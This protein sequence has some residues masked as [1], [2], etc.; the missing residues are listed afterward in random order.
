MDGLTASS[1]CV[2]TNRLLEAGLSK[3]KITLHKAS[4]CL[5]KICVEARRA[6]STAMP[7]RDKRQCDPYLALGQRGVLEHRQVTQGG[8]LL[9]TNNGRPAAQ[10]RG[11]QIRKRMHTASPHAPTL[12][13]GQV[14][15]RLGRARGIRARRRSR[16]RC[17]RCTVALQ[18]VLDAAKH[19][20]SAALKD[21]NAQQAAK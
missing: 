18:P 9:L 17:R 4:F 7:E 6:V 5:N 11:S 19:G 8:Y 14:S 13:T 20:D 21:G 1:S 2:G 12:A 15:V 16:R 3:L 10:Q